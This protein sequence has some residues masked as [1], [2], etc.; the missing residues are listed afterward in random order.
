MLE[1]KKRCWRLNYAREFH[2]DVSPTIVNPGCSNGGELVPDKSLSEF[3]PTN[4]KGYRALFEERASMQPRLKVRKAIASDRQANIE[5]FPVHMRAKG[6]LRRTVQLLKRHRDIYFFEIEADI[7]PISIVITTLAAQA[8]ECCVNTFTFDSEL[9]VVIAT[10]RM[11]PHFIDRPFVNGKLMYVVAN[12]TTVGENFAERWNK[13]PQRATAFSAWHAKALADFENLAEL[14][15]LDRITKKLGD[16]YGKT[17]VARVMDA[18]TEQ[19]SGAR[20][21]QKLFVTPMVGLTLT[22]SAAATAVP[23]NT[24]FGE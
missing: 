2:L 5:P 1:E 24:Y 21:S 17:V 22:N 6:I 14:E 13:E 7:A 15:G 16:S 18:R 8:Y 10:I 19:V 4:P 3:K 12:E 11:M 9:D 23:K 20:A